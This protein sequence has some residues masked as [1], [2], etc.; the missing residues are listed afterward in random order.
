[1]DR[2]ALDGAHRRPRRR[3]AR[4][5]RASGGR[6]RGRG[7]SV[8][9]PRARA[10]GFQELLDGDVE[11]MKTKHPPLRQAPGHVAAQAARRAPDRHDRPDAGGR[12]RRA[13]RH[14]LR[15]SA[16]REVAGA[17]QRLPHLRGGPADPGPD[18]DALRPAFRAGRR[19]RPGADPAGRAGLRRAAA[20]LQPGRL[21]R[22]SCPATARARRSS[23]CGAWLDGRRHVQHPDARGRDPADDHRARRRAASTWAA[24]TS[25]RA[26]FPHGPAD[27][28]ASS[29]SKAR[30]SASSTSRSATRSARSASR[31][32]TRS[33]CSAL[34][35]Q[36]ENAPIFP[37]RTNVELLAR[38]RARRDPRAHLRARCGGDALER[39]RGD[40][41]PPSPM[42]SAAAT[43]P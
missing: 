9:P 26:N 33:T 4:R 20:D 22:P 11:A 39:H 42:C 18:P 25:P 38:A 21:A 2:D 12:R 24:P 23:T 29:T 36:I 3:D 15:L 34:G 31:T 41:A 5:R 8:E 27:G 43:R 19:R 32:P 37:N 17:G 10:L 7:R 30:R 1:M 6:A 13:D 35:P 14:D 28:R 16:V 40:A